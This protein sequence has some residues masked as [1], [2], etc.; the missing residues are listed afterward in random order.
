MV[1]VYFESKIHAEPVAI[2]DSEEMY[3]A[4]FGALDKIARKRGMS[5]TESINEFK[6]MENLV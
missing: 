4:C 6:K 1:T 5:I 3:D 2:F